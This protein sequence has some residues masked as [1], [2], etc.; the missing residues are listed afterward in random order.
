MIPKDIYIYW[1]KIDQPEIVK[2]CINSIKKHCP[3]YTINILN[4]TTKYDIQEKETFGFPLCKY[5]IKKSMSFRHQL[6]NILTLN[7]QNKD[8]AHLYKFTRKTKNFLIL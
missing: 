5:N 6:I 1:D 2:T 4:D 7:K 8:C 3:D